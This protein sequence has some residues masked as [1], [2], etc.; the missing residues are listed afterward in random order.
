METLTHQITQS[1]IENYSEIQSFEEEILCYICQNVIIDP[2]QCIECQNTF[3]KDCLKQW[4]KK[5][6]TCPFRC[7][8]FETKEN[9]LLKRLLSKLQLKCPN[10]CG[11]TISYDDFIKHTTKTCSKIVSENDSI[12]FNDIERLKE[13][14]AQIKLQI[15]KIKPRNSFKMPDDFNEINIKLCQIKI[16]EHK[17]PLTGMKTCRGGWS[18]DLCRKPY[19]S[20]TMSYY[21]TLCDFDCCEECKSSNSLEDVISTILRLSKSTKW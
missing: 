8:T 5:S 12:T 18:C 15:S 14:I 1:L 19:S 7:K 10:K 20:Q 13:K 2:V 11:K 17:H 6:S 21:C 9:K 4:N 3:C 16:K